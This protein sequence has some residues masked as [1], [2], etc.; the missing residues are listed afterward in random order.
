MRTHLLGLLALAAVSALAGCGASTLEPAAAPLMV[1]NSVATN[2]PIPE[3]ASTSTAHAA[4]EPA[5]PPG[6]YEM[7]LTPKEEP[8]PP[9]APKARKGFATPPAIHKKAVLAST[10]K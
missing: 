5:C 1:D 6:Q 3:E 7:A 2:E 10:G 9:P 4:A 8:P